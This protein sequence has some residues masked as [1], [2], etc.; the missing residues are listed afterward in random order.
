MKVQGIIFTVNEVPRKLY[1]IKSGRIRELKKSG[2]VILSDGDYIAI[3][4][5][6]LEIPLYGDVAA[7]EESEIEEV[8]LSEEFENI[9]SRLIKL[10]KENKE[11]NL[12]FSLDD[13]LIEDDEL[14]NVIKHMET[15][16]SLE[17]DDD[18][19]DNEEEALKLIE[20][21]S[22]TQLLTK[23]NYI[24]NFLEKFPNS[25]LG[26]EIILD[27]AKKVYSTLGDRHITKLLC[28]KILLHYPN[29]LKI[30]HSALNLLTLVYKEEGNIQWLTYA[31]IAKY[32]EVILNENN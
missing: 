17:N 21:S 4:E 30:C 9:L 32:V 24:K 1:K 6:L 14:D 2:P 13:F 26:A 5:Y 7:I 18:L 22:D 16:L 23:V 15:L 10:R 20:T 12:D 8:E 29:N 27:T 25:N 19:P 11:N 28:K 31:D 3:A